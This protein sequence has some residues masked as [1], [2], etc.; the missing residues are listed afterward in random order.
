[1]PL[2]RIC[3]CG[4]LIDYNLKMCDK[5][6]KEYDNNKSRYKNYNQQWKKNYHTRK[7]QKL[8]TKVLDKYNNMCVY[9]Y[10]KEGRVIPANNI[11]H[12]ELANEDNFFYFNNLIPLS[13]EAHKEVHRLYDSGKYEI[14]KKELKEMLKR[15][16]V[17]FMPPG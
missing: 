8:R 11:H 4:I 10:L 12:I 7:W 6:N 16:L 13:E 9:T 3:R 14:T 15:F 1:M 5:C 17:E 2:M